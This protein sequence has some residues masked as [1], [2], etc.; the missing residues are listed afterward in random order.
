MPLY[1]Y[2]P[3]GDRCNL[4]GG[5]RGRCKLLRDCA[6]VYGDFLQGRIPSKTC[7]YAGFDPIIC[8]P[9]TKDDRP[10]STT[11]SRPPLVPMTV[12]TTTL[13]PQLP[14][15]IPSLSQSPMGSPTVTQ[16]DRLDVPSPEIPTSFT[17][18]AST[19]TTTEQRVQ[20]TVTD[21]SGIDDESL[22]STASPQAS[23]HS[24]DNNK[25][26]S[27]PQ[28]L[29]MIRDRVV[30]LENLIDSLNRTSTT[31]V[32]STTTTIASTTDASPVEQAVDLTTVS[33]AQLSPSRVSE[34]NASSDSSTGSASI[35]SE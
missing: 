3:I 6:S 16:D 35:K 2:L 11:G 14:T 24:S 30:G 27:W 23:D 5:I 28:L 7:G 1:V 20:S 17:T 19:S 4:N 10:A 26:I 9:F 31:V 22:A 15:T 25:D 12:R 21:R 32:A 13:A 29:N 8:C 34:T 18:V 33:P